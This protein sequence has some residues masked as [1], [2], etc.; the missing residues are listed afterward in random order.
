MSNEHEASFVRGQLAAVEEQLRKALATSA[1]HAAEAR[2]LRGEL[3]DLR[4][5]LDGL[6]V[7]RGD[8][9][10]VALSDLIAHVNREDT[11]PTGPDMTPR[12]VYGVG[13]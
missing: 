10:Q 7:L 8:A 3:G 11:S 6:M 4:D 1:R 12:E 5:A 9:L 13:R 2:E